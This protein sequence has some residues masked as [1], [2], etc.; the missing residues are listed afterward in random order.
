[1]TRRTGCRRRELVEFDL[2]SRYWNNRSNGRPTALKG[3]YDRWVFVALSHRHC[4]VR[5]L[6]ARRPVNVGGRAVGGPRADL[7]MQFQRSFR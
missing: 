5:L 2:K 1:M 4:G 7:R 3:E 6:R